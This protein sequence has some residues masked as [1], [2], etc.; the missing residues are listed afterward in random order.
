MRFNLARLNE[1]KTIT[2]ANEAFAG[3]TLA[4]EPFSIEIQK[5]QRTDQLN[6][7]YDST[8]PDGSFSNALYSQN[9]FMLS[10]KSISGI[11]NEAG[12]HL[13][14]DAVYSI[15]DTEF[16]GR[17]F[18]WNNFP[19]AVIKEITDTIRSFDEIEDKK[20]EELETVS[21]VTQIGA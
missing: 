18:L 19:N 14:L 17:E 1:T 9:L 13:E 16:T 10:L 2:N 12:E 21:S 15:E 7:T 4:D 6:V 5:L 8:K 3:T 11:T 20:K